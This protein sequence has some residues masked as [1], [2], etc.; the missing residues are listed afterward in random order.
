MAL[1]RVTR[2]GTPVR[3][4]LIC[5]PD[6][7]AAIFC[8][9]IDA[10]NREHGELTQENEAAWKAAVVKAEAEMADRLKLFAESLDSTHLGLP[11]T[12]L[13]NATHVTIRGL[14][15]R[16]RHNIA[17]GVALMHPEF[18]DDA[19]KAERIKASHAI[20]LEITRR[21]LLAI[22]GFDERQV[23]CG[24]GVARFPEEVLFDIREYGAFVR[25]IATRMETVSTLGERQASP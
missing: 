7:Q 22:D 21:C 18:V 15:G 9:P 5:D 10:A 14:D 23:V 16:E 8:A 2:G 11:D 20:N 24:D 1:K 3:I 4:P 6:M 25:E 13:K 12:V 17:T 19:N